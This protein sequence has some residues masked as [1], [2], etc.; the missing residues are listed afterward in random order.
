MAKFDEQSGT[1]RHMKETR[2]A[3]LEAQK[4]Q[5]NEEARMIAEARKKAEAKV[6]E[7]EAAIAE[8]EEV[9]AP[10]KSSWEKHRWF[11]PSALRSTRLSSFDAQLWICASAVHVRHGSCRKRHLRTSEPHLNHI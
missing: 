8:L 10:D 6:A 2:H 5:Q 3:A 7:H 9:R 1:I 11:S 4:Q